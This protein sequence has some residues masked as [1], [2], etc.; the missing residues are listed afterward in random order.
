LLLAVAVAAARGRVAFL[1]AFGTVGSL[2]P[3][4]RPLG[5]EPSSAQRAR[6]VELRASGGYNKDKLE[7]EAFFTGDLF[8]SWQGLFKPKEVEMTE[9]ELDA[10][11]K[12]EA[13]SLA[14]EKALT[15]MKLNVLAGED[16]EGVPLRRPA[17]IGILQTQ[18]QQDL[19]IFVTVEE[20]ILTDVLLSMRIENKE[21]SE[22]NVLVVPAFIDYGLTTLLELSPQ[23]RKSKLM[24]QR[25]VASPAAA[26]A[27]DAAVWGEFLAAEFKEADAQG[28]GDKA[29]EQGLAL[30]VRNTGEIVRRGLGRPNWKVVF[31]DLDSSPTLR[32]DDK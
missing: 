10:V 22:R 28:L 13:R 14:A 8:K 4:I 25:S 16:E 31:S 29:R 26:S 32:T 20:K 12:R 3:I 23:I 21:F 27:E 6:C 24:G 17:P 5:C 1:A 19:V 11:A 15:S 2:R 9:E 18:A 30:V 7:K